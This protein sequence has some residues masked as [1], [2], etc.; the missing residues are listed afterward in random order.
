MSGPIK[1]ADIIPLE[2]EFRK[3]Q[4]I[5]NV[6]IY[7]CSGLMDSLWTVADSFLRLHVHR[8]RVSLHTITP[9][10]NALA[11]WRNCEQI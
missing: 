2:F 4:W 1:N 6:Q 7:R 5:I 11:G 9:T 10:T 3:L 8:Q